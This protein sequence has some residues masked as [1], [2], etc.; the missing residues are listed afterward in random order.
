MELNITILVQTCIFSTIFLF[1]SNMFFFSLEKISINRSKQILFQKE[2]IE[3]IKK[4]IYT[5]EKYINSILQSTLN[6]T[7]KIYH[8][9][10]KN[11]VEKHIVRN[12]LLQNKIKENHIKILQRVNIKKNTIINNLHQNVEKFSLKINEKLYIN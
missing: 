4:D 8:K 7:L 10:N 3:N 9:I 1:L 5:H 11:I 2:Y 6:K 12:D